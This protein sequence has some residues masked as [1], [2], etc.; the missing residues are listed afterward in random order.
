M[1]ASS[2]NETGYDPKKTSWS[3]HHGKA[4]SQCCVQYWIIIWRSKQLILQRAVGWSN[5]T[6]RLGD[7]LVDD[8]EGSFKPIYQ[9]NGRMI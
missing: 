4:N 7:I 6:G 9:S 1:A 2:S 3:Y 8:A 5:T